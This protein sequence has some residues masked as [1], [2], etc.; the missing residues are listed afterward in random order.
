MDLKLHLT[1]EALI[2]SK[3]KKTCSFN[4]FKY[5]YSLNFKKQ[6]PAADQDN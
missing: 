3:P 2:G 1:K 6:I 4:I 5:S